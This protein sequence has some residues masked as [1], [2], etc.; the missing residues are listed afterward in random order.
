MVA[1]L[2]AFALALVL[3]VRRSLVV[4]TVRGDS[5]LPSLVSGQRLW[6]RTFRTGLRRHRARAL[7][8]GDVV[9][10]TRPDGD[11]DEWLI[12]RVTALAGGAVPPGSILVR[13][14]NGG[15]DS[16]TFGPLPV[17]AVRAVVLRPLR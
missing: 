6:A 7:K 17:V 4:V 1:A 11:G 9:A 15:Y 10:F 13:G 8:V 3:V 12:K 2:V 16:D 5:M 14:D